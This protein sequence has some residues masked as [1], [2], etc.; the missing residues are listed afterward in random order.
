MNK[1]GEIVVN[2]SS[3]RKHVVELNN[4]FGLLKLLLNVTPTGF[5]II[6]FFNRC[7]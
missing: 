6:V 7:V 1:I 4:P 2:K 5:A 3:E